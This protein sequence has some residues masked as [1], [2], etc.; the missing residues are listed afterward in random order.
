MFR[1]ASSECNLFLTNCWLTSVLP[2][3][4]IRILK[5]INKFTV[6]S[7]HFPREL[8]VQVRSIKVYKQTH[9]LNVPYYI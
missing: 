1:C 6:K 5:A 8:T 4:I 7:V 2:A 3:I 9:F